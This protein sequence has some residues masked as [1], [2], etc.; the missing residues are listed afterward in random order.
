MPLIVSP[1][2]QPIHE[3][4]P[5]ASPPGE[6]VVV[7]IRF[8]V[9]RYGVCATKRTGHKRRKSRKGRAM[10]PGRLIKPLTCGH[11]PRRRDPA[12]QW[13]QPRHAPL[14]TTRLNLH[15]ENDPQND[16]ARKHRATGKPA[17]S[18]LFSPRGVPVQVGHPKGA[19]IRRATTWDRRFRAHRRLS[20]WAAWHDVLVHGPRR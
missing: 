7:T 20:T 12:A 2:V 11:S 13:R 14:T 5:E 15:A 9:R 3:I 19:F 8:P 6:S 17:D 4:L 16:E 10:P 1:E 18:T